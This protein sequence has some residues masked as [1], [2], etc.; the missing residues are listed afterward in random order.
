MKPVSKYASSFALMLALA[1]GCL[2]QVAMAQSADAPQA[3]VPA[4]LPAFIT[5]GTIDPNG[6]IPALNG[7][8]GAGVA[9]L[10]LAQ[11]LTVLVHGSSYMYTVAL[12]N[13]NF[14]GTCTVSYKLTQVQNGKTVTLDSAQ[15]NSFSTVPGDT[16][17]WALSG[18]AIPNSPGLATLQGIVKFGSQT[19][20]TKVNVVLQ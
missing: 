5:A 14:T 17:A 9:N 12:Q 3:A 20:T 6:K 16:W 19:Q 11:P 8:A 4:V 1:I 13:Y 15:I 2:S 18:K 7:V 10:D